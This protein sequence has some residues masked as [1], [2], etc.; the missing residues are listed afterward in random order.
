MQ[1]GQ[2]DKAIAILTPL[3]PAHVDDAAFNY[4]LGMSLLQNKQPNEG[5]V[6]LDRILK[7]GDSAEARLLMGV[8]LRAGSDHTAARD[9]FERAVALNPQLL[10]AHSLYAQAL[11]S[12]GDREK[13]RVAF[14]KELALNPNDFESNSVPGR[15]LQ[16]RAELHRGGAIL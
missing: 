4:L 16:R 13:A 7:Q 8:A 6:Y 14:T 5:A 12:T 10:M 1:L 3:A 9:E 15:D 2:F 11:L